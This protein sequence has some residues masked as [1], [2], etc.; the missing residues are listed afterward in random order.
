MIGCLPNVSEDELKEYERHQW[1][2]K[3]DKE[4]RRDIRRD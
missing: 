3:G 4:G 2:R 1:K